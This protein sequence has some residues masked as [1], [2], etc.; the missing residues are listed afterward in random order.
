MKRIM[1]IV[2]IKVN[3]NKSLITMGTSVKSLL[4]HS[5]H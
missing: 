1:G 3:S 4:R 2:T 5:K